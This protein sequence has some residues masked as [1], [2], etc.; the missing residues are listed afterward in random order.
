MKCHF[1][2]LS[3][4][5][6]IP[7]KGDRYTDLGQVLNRRSGKVHTVPRPIGAVGGTAGQFPSRAVRAHMRVV[8]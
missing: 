1:N 6:P 4:K 3:Q 2:D 5:L 7:L 8:Y